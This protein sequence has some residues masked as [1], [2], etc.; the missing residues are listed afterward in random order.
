MES[1]MKIGIALVI[2][3]CSLATFWV[4]LWGEETE[5]AFDRLVYEDLPSEEICDEPTYTTYLIECEDGWRTTLD[6]YNEL[7]EDDKKEGCNYTLIK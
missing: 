6:F 4:V 1:T 3:I 5:Q 7:N 2:L